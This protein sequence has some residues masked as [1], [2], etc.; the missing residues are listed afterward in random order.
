MY[1]VYLYSV[2]NHLPD[3]KPP[4]QRIQHKC[5]DQ[6]VALSFVFFCD[7]KERSQKAC[8]YR[9][10]GILLEA[11]VVT[12]AALHN[13]GSGVVSVTSTGTN[14]APTDASP[15]AVMSLADCSTT[16]W[17]TTTSVACIGTRGAGLT[18][19]SGLTIAGVVG[20][21]SSVFSFDGEWAMIT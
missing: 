17:T 1:R 15:V 4:V 8:S 19:V 2:L 16:S 6:G 5:L 11:P 14:F 18:G 3:C 12:A 21:S 10:A 7:T 13:V 9:V 20:S